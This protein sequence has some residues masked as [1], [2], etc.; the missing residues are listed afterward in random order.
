MLSDLFRL[1]LTLM[2]NRKNADF[3]SSLS[4]LMLGEG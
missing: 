2:K 1:S 4:Q 3:S